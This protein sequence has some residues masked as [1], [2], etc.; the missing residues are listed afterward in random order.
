MGACA[1]RLNQAAGMVASMG[2]AKQVDDE[3]RHVEIQ[4]EWME[5]FGVDAIQL[6]GDAALNA[7]H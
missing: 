3:C 2:L 6:V 4:R 7:L 1:D 5:G